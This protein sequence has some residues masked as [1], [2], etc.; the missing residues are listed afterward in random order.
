MTIK[1]LAPL[2]FTFL[3]IAIIFSGYKVGADMA[4]RDNAA[5]AAAAAQCVGDSC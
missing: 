4:K 3:F 1:K 2:L 5:D